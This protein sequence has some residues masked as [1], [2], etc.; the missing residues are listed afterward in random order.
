[1]ELDGDD[2]AS[3]TVEPPPFWREV[4]QHHW[5]RTADGLL[6]HPDLARFVE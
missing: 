5:H 6:V 4:R 2:D 1:L 3:L